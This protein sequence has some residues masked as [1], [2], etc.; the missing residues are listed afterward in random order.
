MTE[1]ASTAVDA[2]LRQRVIDTIC[3]VLPRVLGRDLP[4]VSADT[5][6]MD[7]ELTSAS[8]LEM[9]LEVEDALEIQVDVEDF[10]REH[11]ETIGTLATYV[12]GHALA[13]G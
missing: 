4:D 5:T 9:M 11:L 13:D 8:T 1:L 3:E 7:L 6:L 2:E 12:A 10:D